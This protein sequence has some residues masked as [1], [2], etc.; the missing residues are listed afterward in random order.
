MQALSADERTALLRI[1]GASA[2]STQGLRSR[3]KAALDAY[4]YVLSQ[5]PLE[6][7]EVLAAARALIRTWDEV[8]EAQPRKPSEVRRR[9]IDAILLD[10]VVLEGAGTEQ[11]T[12]MAIRDVLDSYGMR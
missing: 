11:M 6:P 9:I 7:I 5:P 1:L 2:R 8:K 3:Q 10:P 12:P 4:L